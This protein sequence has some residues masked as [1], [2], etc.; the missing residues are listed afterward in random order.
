[1]ANTLCEWTR[2]LVLQGRCT[3]TPWYSPL[4]AKQNVSFQHQWWQSPS[5]SLPHGDPRAGVGPH[6]DC[7]PLLC[8][9]HGG[10][11]WECCPHSGHCDRQHP[12]CTH[13][14]LPLPSLIHWPGPQLHHCAQDLGH[15]VASCWWD[16]LCGMP[17]PDVLCPFYLCSGVLGSSCH[18]LWSVCGYLQPTEIHHHP[19]PHRH[20]QNWPCGGIP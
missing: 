18:G 9:V 19:Q 20:R 17:S 5:H 15:F 14:P 6:L 12:S 2:H 11:D 8:L 4:F 13:V 16:F 3:I 10:A 7:H 1:M